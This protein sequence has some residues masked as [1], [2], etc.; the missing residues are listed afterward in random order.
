MSALALTNRHV[1][2]QLIQNQIPR[3]I[4]NQTCC[5]VQEHRPNDRARV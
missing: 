3:V 4:E 5:R 2:M 1:T